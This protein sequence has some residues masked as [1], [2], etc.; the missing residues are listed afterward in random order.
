MADHSSLGIWYGSTTHMCHMANPESYTYHGVVLTKLLSNFQNVS[1]ISKGAG[2]KWC[3]LIDWNPSV[4]IP[5][6][7]LPLN[8]NVHLSQSLNLTLVMESTSN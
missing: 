4:L 3:T 5:I 2:C 7:N 8:R 6:P 1:T